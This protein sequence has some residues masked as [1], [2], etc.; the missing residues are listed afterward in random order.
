MAS[1][2]SFKPLGTSTPEI[3]ITEQ[4]VTGEE[5][6]LPA[7]MELGLTRSLTFHGP[8][9]QKKPAAE[10]QPMLVSPRRTVD[11]YND[12]SGWAIPKVI[13]PNP[14]LDRVVQTY[15]QDGKIL[16]SIPAAASP[17]S[18]RQRPKLLSELKRSIS[19][20]HLGHLFHHPRNTGGSGPSSIQGDRAT[21][22][23]HSGTQSPLPDS[24]DVQEL[25]RKHDKKTCPD[26]EAVSRALNS[27]RVQSRPGDNEYI[28]SLTRLA[29]SLELSRADS[30]KALIQAMQARDAGRNEVCRSLCLSIVQ[31]SHADIDTRVYSYNILSTLA[32]PG[33][34]MNYLAEAYALVQENQDA[35]P[36]CAKLLGVIALLKDGAIEKD[37]GRVSEKAA[38]AN[39]KLC[40]LS[41]P[42]TI[43]REISCPQKKSLEIPKENM[44]SGMLTPKSEKI[45]GWAKDSKPL[46]PKPNS[47][48]ADLSI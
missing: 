14:P 24:P 11:S 45:V 30:K 2:A 9:N 32:S 12:D 21:V 18:L 38:Q 33:Q 10:S 6:R 7:P 5:L 46:K 43:P 31:N 27:L 23:R 8:D 34:A 44:P 15:G 42:P 36:E 29:T 3:T 1:P 48:W 37:G 22:G 41:M 35:H 40:E 16:S 20:S 25:F 13:P 4:E 26:L 39:D 28:T 19:T 47:L 17:A